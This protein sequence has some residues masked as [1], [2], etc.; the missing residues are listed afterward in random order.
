MLVRA[1]AYCF[2][3]KFSCFRFTKSIKPSK[4]RWT[5]FGLSFAVVNIIKMILML[6]EGRRSPVIIW[7]CL[8]TICE[9][10]PADH[11]KSEKKVVTD[12]KFCVLFVYLKFVPTISFLST[13]IT[14]GT[15]MFNG[16]AN[17]R[18]F[19]RRKHDKSCS[20]YP[21]FLCRKIITFWNRNTPR[22]ISEYT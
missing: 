2:S 10:F 15:N 16:P 9:I 5:R 19:H 13:G 3:V 7:L 6:H 1:P 20:K 17:L 4:G 12:F 22:S 11:L 18:K 21:Y 8:F 14:R